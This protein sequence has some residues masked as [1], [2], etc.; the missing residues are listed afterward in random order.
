MISAFS[1]IIGSKV[2]GSAFQ[3]RCLAVHVKFEP[4]GHV[5]NNPKQF[6]KTIGVKI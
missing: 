5:A 4:I 3:V 2:P 1:D 6:F